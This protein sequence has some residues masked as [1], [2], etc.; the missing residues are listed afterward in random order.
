MAQFGLGATPFVPPANRPGSGISPPTTSLAR[1]A[2]QNTPLRRICGYTQVA[3][4]SASNL[5]LIAIS[6]GGSQL[7]VPGQTNYQG[8]DIFTLNVATQALMTAASEAN[9]FPVRLDGHVEAGVSY[10]SNLCK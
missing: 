10:R 8:T 7:Y 6:A 5:K 4:V 9:G 3:A 2:N 1:F